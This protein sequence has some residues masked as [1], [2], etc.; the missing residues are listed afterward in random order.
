AVREAVTD[1]PRA[2]SQ[3]TYEP[4]RSLSRLAGRRRELRAV[5]FFLE[6]CARDEGLR[7]IL[8]VVD[9]RRDGEPL[10]AVGFRMAIE[11]FG[12]NGVFADRDAV[13]PQVAFLQPCRHDLERAAARRGGRRGAASTTAT[14]CAATSAAG[15]ARAAP[16]GDFPFGD[17]IALP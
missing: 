1:R 15:S 8:R 17:G 3:I 16:A 13:L 4:R 5:G 11:V 6:V 2:A 12:D 7:E 10:G 14:A 9:N